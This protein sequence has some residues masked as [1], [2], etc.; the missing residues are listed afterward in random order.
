MQI[1]YGI[2]HDVNQAMKVRLG[3]DAG[4]DCISA[5]SNGE[6]LA[7]LLDLLSREELCRA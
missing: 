1:H 5:S 6:G 3:T 7:R 4:F 2:L